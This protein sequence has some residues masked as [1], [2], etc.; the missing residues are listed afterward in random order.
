[1]FNLFVLIIEHRWLWLQTL[2]RKHTKMDDTIRGFTF[3]STTPSG[4][5]IS[6]VIF[7]IYNIFAHKSDCQI[8]DTIPKYMQQL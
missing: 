3:K 6:I 8:A 5:Q 1:M 4:Y 7:T 2:V